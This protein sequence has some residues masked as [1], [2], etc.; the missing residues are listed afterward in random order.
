M[1]LYSL[2]PAEHGILASRPEHGI[3]YTH[4]SAFDM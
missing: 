2:S 3:G 4:L 1:Y